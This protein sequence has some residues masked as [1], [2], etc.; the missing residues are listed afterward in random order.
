MYEFAKEESSTFDL[1]KNVSKQGLSMIEF[2][3][4]TILFRLLESFTIG[5]GVESF[6]FFRNSLVDVSGCVEVI[7]VE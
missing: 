2:G 7:V 4:I 6:S 5:L 3:D 1:P